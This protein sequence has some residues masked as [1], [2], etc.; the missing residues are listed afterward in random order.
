MMQSS[1]LDLILK[2]YLSSIKVGGNKKKKS[3]L[4][5]TVKSDVFMWNCGIVKANKLYFVCHAI[6]EVNYL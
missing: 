6:L 5:K 2:H 1:H 4:K 3:L